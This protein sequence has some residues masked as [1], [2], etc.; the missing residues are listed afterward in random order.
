MLQDTTA[1]RVAMSYSSQEG[2]LRALSKI[3]LE[4]RLQTRHTTREADID[5]CRAGQKR[6]TCVGSYQDQPILAPNVRKQKKAK[7]TAG[8]LE[9]SLPILIWTD[10]D[11]CQAWH[12]RRQQMQMKLITWA[13][14]L[15]RA[16]F[17]QASPIWLI[18]TPGPHT[19]MPEC[20]HCSVADIKWRLFSSTSPL[21]NMHEVSP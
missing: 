16:A 1:F 21:A 18:G 5:A 19:A 7:K 20:K 3:P 10:P 8:I 17:P 6:N 14:L 11:L 4:N 2:T 15:F 9:A 13:H 12:K